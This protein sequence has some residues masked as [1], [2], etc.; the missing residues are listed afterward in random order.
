VTTLDRARA[1]KIIAAGYPIGPRMH[2]C[3]CTA[4]RH[5]HSGAKFTGGHEPTGCRRYR[6][7][8]A[9]ALAE[10]AMEADRSDVL[11]DIVAWHTSLY[12]R[13]KPTPGGWSIGPSDI[14]NCRRR[15][16]LRERP[17][18]DLI[19]NDV[20]ESAAVLGDIWHDVT[21]RARQY[22]YP[23]RK[24]EFELAIPGLDRPGRCDEYDPLTATGVDYK[25]LSE[26]QWEV[27][28]DHGA[29]EK[30]WGQLAVY[31]YALTCLGYEVTVMRIIYIRRATG[32]CEYHDRPYSEAYAKDALAELTSTALALD[33]GQ[34]L[35]RDGRGPSSDIIC[36]K[37]CDVR[38]YC[39]NV[40]AAEAAGRSPESYTL[41]GEHPEREAIEWA[42]AQARD[43]KDNESE[44]TREYKAAVPLL[45]GVPDGTYGEYVVK[46][47][48][49]LMPDYKSYYQGVMREYEVYCL[50]PADQRGEFADWLARIPLPHR[51]DTW[52]EVKRVRHANRKEVTAP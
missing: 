8:N 29:H 35:P 21:R 6:R 5:T 10:K 44:A 30:H 32:E 27:I 18:A 4:P 12:P 23:W 25:T 47:K 1:R 19:R 46:E 39:W 13:P 37:F 16:Q 11:D 24:Y 2:P 36:S 42:A 20:D 38:D 33:L 3:I 28:G 50:T 31:C 40:K 43:W 52:T 26:Y 49:R 45:G 14:G 9:D 51:R 17:P 41:L 15:I 22:R 7:D 48:S 34:E